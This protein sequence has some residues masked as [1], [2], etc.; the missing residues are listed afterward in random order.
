[1]PALFMKKISCGCMHSH[2]C[3]ASYISSDWKSFPP[4]ASLN[5]PKIGSL[6]GVRSGKCGGWGRCWMWMPLI[7]WAVPQTV[8][9]LISCCY[10][11]PAAGNLWS[12]DMMAGLRWLLWRWKCEALGTG[13]FGNVK[14]LQVGLGAPKIV[15]ASLSLQMSAC[16]MFWVLVSWHVAVLC[17]PTSFQAESSGHRCHLQSQCV[18]AGCHI[19][20]CIINKSCCHVGW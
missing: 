1:M 8:C 10:K 15:S 3:S 12:F 14:A 7:M 18:S 6:K 9:G 2:S 11:T 13:P 20:F 17:L 19:L 4:R 5:G 16:G